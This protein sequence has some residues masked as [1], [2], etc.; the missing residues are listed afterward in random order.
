MNGLSINEVREFKSKSFDYADLIIMYL[1]ALSIDCVFAVFNKEI[2]PLINAINKLNNKRIKIIYA[3][4]ECA[5]AFMADG[6]YRETGKL[7][8]V[9]S[10]SGFRASNLITGVTSASVDEA[11]MLIIT[12]RA[13]SPSIINMSVKES[14]VDILNVFKCITKYNVNIFHE[15]QLERA[16][17]SG[18]LKAF[19]IPR[20][21]VHISISSDILKT[22]KQK[23]EAEISVD[24][25]ISKSSL[26]DLKCIKK[27]V[28]EISNAKKV[29][30]FLGNGCGRAY[31]SIE[32]LAEK[33][34]ANF[35]SGPT[36]K[37][38]VNEKHPLYR[39]VY[40]YAGHQSA[41]E[42]FD[43]QCL[44]LILFFGASITDMGIGTL[45]SD[46]THNKL[47]HIDYTTDNFSRSSSAKM[48]I[49]GD[50]NT[51]VNRLLSD[52]PENLN[53]EYEYGEVINELGNYFT[54]QNGYK[55]LSNSMPIKPQRLMAYLTKALPIDTR[56]F[57][58]TGNIWAWATHYLTLEANNGMYHVSMEY[59]CMSW[60][61]SAVIGSATASPKEPHVCL[62]GD[63]AWLMGSHELITAVQYK[64]PIV[65]FILNDSAFGMIRFGQKL[66]KAE[67]IGWKLNKVDFAALAKAQGA[68]GIIIEDPRQLEELDLDE[69]FNQNIPTLIDVRI[70]PNEVPPMMVRVKSLLSDVSHTPGYK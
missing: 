4:H 28:T 9:L 1:Q 49:T 22:S 32:K 8:V 15:E 27:L 70:D 12:I 55:C 34:G 35:I 54:I 56:V 58:D 18:L 40:G 2:T 65:F 14:C 53:Y 26:E 7:G 39:G 33:L 44:E 30:I 21:P 45:S 63:G 67:S 23:P 41:K 47:I 48:H 6:Y 3:Q 42:L 46:K 24:Y 38:W 62:T 25:L 10:S 20:G 57:I 61:I 36:S 5:A 11:A 50:L 52:L 31:S 69:L 51:T 13:D 16:L 43:D 68:N 64:L 59:G 17:L 29:V 66:S 37:R 19:Q 60:S